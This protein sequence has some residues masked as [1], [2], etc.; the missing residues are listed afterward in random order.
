ME[1]RDAPLPVR[2]FGAIQEDVPSSARRR[3]LLLDLDL[4]DLARM[5]NDFAN[6]GPVSCANFSEDSLV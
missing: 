4:D 5:K 1:T 3:L 6:V 2:D